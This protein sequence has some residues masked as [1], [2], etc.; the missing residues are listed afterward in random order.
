[1]F[2]IPS[3]R[4]TQPQPV[5]RRD[6]DAVAPGVARHAFEANGGHSR[7]CVRL[8]YRP[9]MDPLDDA[10]QRELDYQLRQE[11]WSARPWWLRIL[12]VLGLSLVLAGLIGLFFWRV[13]PD[14]PWYTAAVGLA[15]LV[16]SSP[17]VYSPRRMVTSHF[18]VSTVSD[19]DARRAKRFGS[20]SMPD[21]PRGET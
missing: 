20:V 17:L 13:T 11:P 14:W 10:Q 4:V 21:N 19:A 6:E 2:G 8:P 15:V 18:F 7:C 3:T 12:Y 16:A 5:L 9:C 1:M